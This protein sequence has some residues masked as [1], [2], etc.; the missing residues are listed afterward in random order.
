MVTLRKTGTVNLVHQGVHIAK[1]WIT[2]VLVKKDL[3]SV[4]DIV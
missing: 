4:M 1:L 2:V 3:I